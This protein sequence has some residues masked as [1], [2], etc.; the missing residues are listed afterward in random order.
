VTEDE[1]VLQAVEALRSGDLPALGQI[2][3]AGHASLRDDYEV[4]VPD[5]DQLVE[6][7]RDEDAVYGA[8]MTGG[9][10][11]GSIVALATRGH[12]STA[13]ARIVARYRACA[14]QAAHILIAGSPCAPC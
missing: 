11:G 4:S 9:G 5:V 2:L 10:F 6:L 12:G 3:D 14:A 13:A 8:R 7:A 1:R